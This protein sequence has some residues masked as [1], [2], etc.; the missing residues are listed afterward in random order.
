[1]SVF[2]MK[3]K[4][5][6]NVPQFD[7]EHGQLFQ[8]ADLL[9]QQLLDQQDP[10]AARRTFDVLDRYVRTHFA[11][12]ERVM[13]QYGYPDY[14]AHRQIHRNLLA[15][16]TVMRQQLDDWRPSAVKMFATS[17]ALWAAG[18]IVAEDTKLG[19]FLQAQP[20]IARAPA[21]ADAAADRLDATAE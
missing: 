6:I 19:K 14:Y 11:N 15:Q 3:S 1:M 17:I 12:E 4:H 13:Q 2:R 16:L 18:H 8:I 7:E 20:E 5:L 21:Y 10:Q 9:R